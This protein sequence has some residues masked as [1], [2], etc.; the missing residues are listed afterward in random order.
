MGNCESEKNTKAILLATSKNFNQIN[1]KK[2]V[3]NIIT[4]KTSVNIS[5]VNFYF[6]FSTGLGFLFLE[7]KAQISDKFF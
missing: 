6:V 2:I 1:N 5:L 4:Y 7:D 3:S